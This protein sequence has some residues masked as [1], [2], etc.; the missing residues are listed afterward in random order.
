MKFKAAILTKLN[1]D[2]VI[3]D[4]GV[5][6]LINGQVLVKVLYSGI[7]GAQ[8]QEIAGK[9]GNSK[10]LPHLLGHE[11]YGQVV[12]THPSVTK[13]KQGDYVVMHW[14]QGSG[15]E[16]DFPK[17]E[18]NGKLISSGKVTT[19]NEYSICSEN[20]LTKLN[21]PT[22]PYLA[23][24]L[25]CS[26]TTAFGVV[27]R[28]LHVKLGDNALVLGCGGVGLS[29]IQGLK[30]SGAAKIYGVDINS[31]SKKN[32]AYKAG[33]TSFVDG[34]KELD[35][36]FE[37]IIDTT[38][39]SKVMNHYKKYLCDGGELVI[40]GQPSIKEESS[41][42]TNWG[43]LFGKSYPVK[44]TFSQGGGT[45]PDIDIPKYIG[46]YNLNKF[47][48]HDLVTDI[49][50]FDDIN[51]AINTLRSGNSGRILIEV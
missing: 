23:C 18:F 39:N 28:D 36:K 35:S 43:T 17:Y 7:C 16:S 15:I 24:L 48:S 9:K 2:L 31:D 14:R 27:T 46:L 47:N 6:P 40:V 45:V 38:G 8:L 42:I 11:G 20:R 30:L 34:I 44:I 50:K 37:F 29:I 4:I 5:T 22:D 21:S 1:S 41:D 26:L 12:D 32:L 3:D 33:A 13:V 25:G 19:F 10:F 51:K 49:F